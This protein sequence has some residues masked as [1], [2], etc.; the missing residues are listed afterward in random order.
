M[1]DPSTS[2]QRRQLL[3]LAAAGLTVRI[4]AVALV[5]HASAA[6]GA[7][8]IK[9][10]NPMHLSLEADCPSD[11][12]FFLGQWTVSH[13][14]LKDRL[15]GSTEWEHFKG[16]CFMHKILGGFGNIDD[17][18]VELPT[19]IYRAATLRSFDPKSRTWS[20][21]WLDA[22]NPG[23]L[24]VPV[25]GDFKDGVGTF[26]ANDVLNGKPIVVRFVWTLPKPESPQWEQAF[27]PDGG[28]TWETN[29]IMNFSRP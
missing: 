12:D 25:V 24:D 2:K 8:L 11:F 16:S 14:R 18:I 3:K 15:V 23:S 9:G 22:R 5:M 17:N 6:N 13:Q 29:W 7:I 10:Q 19:G 1:S 27:S 26:L 21:W 4:G 28:K 20:I